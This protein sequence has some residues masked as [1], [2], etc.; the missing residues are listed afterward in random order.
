MNT[1]IE[2]ELYLITS[3]NKVIKYSE[4]GEEVKHGNVPEF[5]HLPFND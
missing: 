1:W 2:D 3:S 4:N 5:D